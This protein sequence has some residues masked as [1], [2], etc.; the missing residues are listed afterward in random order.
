MR[1]GWPVDCGP[2]PLAADAGYRSPAQSEPW[3]ASAA[4]AGRGAASMLL[5][6]LAIERSECERAGDALRATA[7]TRG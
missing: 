1:E 4:S 3:R 7:A 6:A 5:W 2:E